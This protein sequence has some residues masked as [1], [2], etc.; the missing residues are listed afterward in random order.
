MACVMW[1]RRWCDEVGVTGV[2]S[3]SEQKRGVVDMSVVAGVCVVGEMG[4]G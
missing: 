3:A 4:K 2:S 1:R